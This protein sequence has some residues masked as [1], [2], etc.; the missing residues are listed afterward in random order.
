MQM[1]GDSKMIDAN[2]DK[3]CERNN[4]TIKKIEKFFNEDNSLLK[5]EWRK[6]K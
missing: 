1:H 4:K 2:A 3:E 5:S 6:L